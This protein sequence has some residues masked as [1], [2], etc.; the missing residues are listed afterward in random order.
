MIRLDKTIRKLQAVADSTVSVGTHV[1]VSFV[2]VTM[3]GS[4]NK[5]ASQLT[6]GNLVADTDICAAPP[7]NFVREIDTVFITNKDSA[8]HTFTVKIDESA[9]DYICIVHS[10]SSGQS[11]IYE[12]N[13]GWSVL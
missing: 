9:T 11:L 8:A 2:D 4:N 12:H 6:N 5:G 10:L 13:T 7:Q 3:D 1:M